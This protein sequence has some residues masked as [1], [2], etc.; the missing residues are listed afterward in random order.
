[1]HLGLQQ[2]VDVR[3]AIERGEII[4]LL[5][6]AHKARRNSKFILNC[7]DDSAFAAAVQLGNDKTS[8]SDCALEF[9]RLTER[10]AAS[11]RIDYQQSFMR[12][13]RV[14]FAESA[15]D[16][17]QLGYQI[18]FRVHSA[19]GVAQEKFDLALGGRLICFVTKCGRIGII[20]A[21]NHFDPEP[22]CPDAKLLDGSGAK[23]V[24]CCQQYTMSIVLKTMSQFR[25]RCCLASA[26]YPKEQNYF[27][28]RR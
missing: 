7:D 17:L 27:W 3:L 28:L 14:V 9:A 12:R 10:I 22:F 11:R 26:V 4:E 2:I 5:A 16:L 21:L 18:Y 23:S 6:G 19:G 1:M 15:F 25:C 8:E 13:A 20:L 24:G